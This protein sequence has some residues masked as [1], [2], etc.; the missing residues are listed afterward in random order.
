[1]NFKHTVTSQMTKIRINFEMSDQ[2]CHLEITPS[3]F[4]EEISRS[5]GQ[6]FIRY[7]KICCMRIYPQ[8]LKYTP[9][10]H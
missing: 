2:R 5:I 6:K 10:A 7:K 4:E 3:T 9:N 1:M 8:I